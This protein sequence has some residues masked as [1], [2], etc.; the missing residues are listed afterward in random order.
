MTDVAQLYTRGRELVLTKP[1]AAILWLGAG[2]LILDLFFDLATGALPY[3][4]LAGYIW[5]GLTVGLI[6]GLAGVGLSMTYS[7]LN[8]ANFA[9]GDYITS[10]AFMGWAAAY[11]VA[12]LGSFELDSLLLVGAGGSVYASELGINV[13]S[14]P[15]AVV[16]G[17]VVAA[18]S[19]IALALII[20]RVTFKPMREQDGI[21]LLITSVGVALALRYGIVFIFQQNTRSLTANVPQITVPVIDGTFNISYHEV[22]LVLTAF[23]LMLGVHVILQRTK[24]GKAMRAMAD[25][26]DLALVT[27][28]ASLA[29]LAACGDGGGSDTASGSS[30]GPG[31]S[32]ADSPG[33]RA[34]SS[35]SSGEPSGSISGGCSCFSSS[36]RSSWAGSARSTEPSA[37]AS[38]SDWRVASR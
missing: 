31:S 17:I 4:Q 14:K 16:V 15:L 18:L 1:F 36:L 23:V 29:L 2:L 35:P 27:G 12:G 26:E 11:L 10:G 21:T 38:S 20:D 5:N 28:I 8:F 22:T 33:P 6:I 34:S 32:V 13:L 25:N 9:H 19:T 3:H 30:D 24:L 7:I 37:V